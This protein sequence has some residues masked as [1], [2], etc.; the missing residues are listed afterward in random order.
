MSILTHQLL[1]KPLNASNKLHE[2]HKRGVRLNPPAYGP[3]KHN[4]IMIV[5]VT[6][7]FPTI[8]RESVDSLCRDGRTHHVI[9]FESLQTHKLYTYKPFHVSYCTPGVLF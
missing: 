2:Y 5:F 7:T 8:I 9:H 4:D 1:D 3:G 6:I